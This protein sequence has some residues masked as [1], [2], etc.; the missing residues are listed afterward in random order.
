MAFPDTAVECCCGGYVARAYVMLT[1]RDNR[2]EVAVTPSELVHYMSPRCVVGYTLCVMDCSHYAHGRTQRMY[3]GI[4][5]FAVFFVRPIEFGDDIKEQ[6][7]I[8]I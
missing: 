8:V 1:E 5:T 4:C 3:K 6:V 7:I 2:Q